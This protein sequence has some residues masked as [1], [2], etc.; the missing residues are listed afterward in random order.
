M[1]GTSH[2]HHIIGS[3]A[4]GQLIAC[5][6]TTADIPNALVNRKNIS[7]EKTISYFPFSSS[8]QAEPVR[9][10]LDYDALT[11]NTILDV[12]W[13]CVKSYQLESALQLVKPQLNNNTI[14]ILTQNGMGHLE[15]AQKLLCPTLPPEQIFVAV[16]THGSLRVIDE[17]LPELHHTGLGSLQIGNNYLVLNN[18]AKP[19][20]LIKQ[21]AS[22]INLSWHE[23]IEMA[24]W[25]KLGI[26]A[27]INPLTAYYQ[28]KNGDLLTQT[29]RQ[30][31]TDMLI[32][33]MESFYKAID[34]EELAVTFKDDCYQ[35]IKNTSNNFS[36]MMLDTKNGKQTEIESITGYLLSQ[37][38]GVRLKMI[39][40]QKQYHRIQKN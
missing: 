34:M 28:C 20:S 10:T 22:V 19:L 12:V 16:N 15:T 39:G 30:M 1:A 11:D 35:V 6:L 33:E 26:S 8:G 24:L 40:H 13:V 4:V 38:N 7:E 14:L 27:V 25:I 9:L 31:E 3:G 32:Q 17:S 37:A 36:S 21:V 18:Q 5:L 23:Q 29:E 2:H